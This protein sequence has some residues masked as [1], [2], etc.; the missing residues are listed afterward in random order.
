MHIKTSSSTDSM[1]FRKDINGL[2]A[3]A[4]LM[5]L[6]FHF[7]PEIF[8]AGFI[9]VDVFFVISGYL[10]TKIIVVRELSNEFSFL[11]FYKARVNRLLPA[12][13]FLCFALLFLG[14]FWLDIFAFLTLVKNA[15]S[16]LVAFSNFSYATQS[17]Y[18]DEAA[19]QNWL[20]HTWS[21]SLEWQFY[22]FYPLA[23]VMILRYSSLRIL[24]S[25]IIIATLLSF[26]IGVYA[27]LKFPELSYYMLPSRMWEFMVGGLA[28]LYPYRTS[29]NSK[30]S[31]TLTL[32]GFILLF[33]GTLQITDETPWPGIFT[34]LP[35]F[36]TYLIIQGNVKSKLLNSWLFQRVGIYSYSIYLWH[37]PFAVLGDY[38]GVTYWNIIGMI[39]SLFAGTVSY[40]LVES[41]QIKFSFMKPIRSRSSALLVCL[42][43]ISMCLAILMY[44][45]FSVK[46]NPKLMEP[47]VKGHF[48][49]TSEGLYMTPPEQINIINPEVEG[50]STLLIGDSHSAHYAYGINNINEDR[51][52][53]SWTG[54]CLSLPEYMTH[55]AK[56]WMNEEWKIFCRSNIDLID[57]YPTLNVMMA[58]Q[59]GERPLICTSNSCA[60]KIA[61]NYY[62]LLV[63]QLEKVSDR[64][65]LDRSLFIIGQVPAP[66]VSIVQCLKSFTKKDCE[67]KTSKFRGNIIFD[68]KILS[69]FANSRKNV[70]FINPFN[71]IC[72][73]TNLCVLSI[74]GNSIF[75]DEGH[76]TQFGSAI[77]WRYINSE[78]KKINNS[79]SNRL[80]D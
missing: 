53:L 6:L 33:F 3:L 44:I 78:M 46:K 51:I 69:D 38:I 15:L 58:Q 57:Y 18:F 16:S 39:I 61:P 27:S 65:G 50:N 22:I 71:A 68:N 70:F 55:G 74:N 10:M 21:L 26:F 79:A 52:L 76:L 62:S 5:V 75:Y 30:Y 41:R 42:C 77:I 56:S 60:E 40:W 8:P 7:N 14:Y 32:L 2:R 28:F 20:L 47:F 45:N 72:D 59:W 12:L 9:G 48:Q 73:S 29:N 54:S 64:V 36:A 67:D 17:G 49:R 11:N 37:W 34:L 31:S 19:R 1:S 24:K 66:A 35:V 25:S 80:H 43:S 4:V 63:D 13:S 23:V